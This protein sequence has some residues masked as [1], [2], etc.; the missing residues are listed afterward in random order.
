MPLVLS[1][2]ELVLLL[3]IILLKYMY[4]LRGERQ[5]LYFFCLI[6]IVQQIIEAYVYLLTATGHT[7]GT[8]ITG[9]FLVFH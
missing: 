4:L 7:F 3:N 9:D 5:V 1:L 8:Q 2:A 6:D